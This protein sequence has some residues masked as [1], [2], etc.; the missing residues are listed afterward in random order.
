MDEIKREKK[1]SILLLGTSLLLPPLC[2]SLSSSLSLYPLYLRILSPSHLYA[3]SSIQVLPHDK[4]VS[5]KWADFPAARSRL[6]HLVAEVSKSGVASLILSGDV[7]YGE[8]MRMECENA[9]LIEVCVISLCLS[10]SLSLCVFT[11]TVLHRPL[12]L[13]LPTPASPNGN[14]SASSLY[15]SLH[16]NTKREFMVIRTL[17]R[18]IWIGRAIKLCILRYGTSASV[19]VLFLLF[20][21]LLF[22]SLALL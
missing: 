15:T 20:S 7:H 3:G 17:G 16:R 14:S 11:V 4:P 18:S 22:L 2:I 8:T 12:L 1:K 10:L 9:E 19:S 6:L 5:E 21:S 13:A